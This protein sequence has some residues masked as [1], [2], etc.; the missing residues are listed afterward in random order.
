LTE[1]LLIYNAK[2]LLSTEILYTNSI[3]LAGK[4]KNENGVEQAIELIEAN[5]R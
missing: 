5:K 4:I 2:S 1:K 3:A